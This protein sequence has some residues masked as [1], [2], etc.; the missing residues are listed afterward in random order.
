MQIQDGFS[1]VSSNWTEIKVFN[2][3]K[4]L[5]DNGICSWTHGLETCSKDNHHKYEEEFLLSEHAILIIRLMS[6][7]LKETCYRE[8]QNS[9]ITIQIYW[10][11][12]RV[13]LWLLS[14]FT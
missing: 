5:P 11:K 14:C 12:L 10:I 2:T 9:L 13:H 8:V 6:Q 7:I 1:V 3:P 4:P